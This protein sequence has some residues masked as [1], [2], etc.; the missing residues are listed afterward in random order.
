MNT[1]RISCITF[2]TFHLPSAVC[3]VQ[4]LIRYSQKCHSLRHLNNHTLMCLLAV[5]T[6]TILVELPNSEYYLWTDQISIQQTWFCYG[7][8]ISFFS[9]SALNR[10][11]MAFLSIE[12]HFF[13]FRS[14]TYVTR[15]ARFIYHYLP[16]ILITVIIVVYVLI[17][18]LFLSCGKEFNYNQFLCG[19]TCGIV[20]L[21]LG[22]FYAWFCVF[23]PIILTS[24]A[25]ILLPIRYTLQR[26]NIRRA[27]SWQQTRKLIIQTILIVSVY[28]MCWLPYTIILQLV[29]N[30]AISFD[31]EF[32]ERIFT[33]IPYITSVLTPFLVI[34]T[35]PGRIKFGFLQ[36]RNIRL[37]TFRTTIIPVNPIVSV[38][39]IGN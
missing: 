31:D 30:R 37:L 21:E 38:R 29:I 11:F 32:L 5:A 6:W 22:T 17:T 19:F 18:H 34:Y 12:R 24:F 36:N 28:L 25:C 3:A 39:P 13:V 9:M 35:K 2:I 8:N 23:I 4:I 7:Y 27:A 1:G 20:I 15:R 16:L 10:F 26:K 33:V 14:H